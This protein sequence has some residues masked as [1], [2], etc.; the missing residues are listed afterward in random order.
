MD[1]MNNRQIVLLTMLTS[2][3]VSIAT[4]IVTVAMLEE[5]PPTLTQTVNRVVERTIER[6]VTGSSTP[7][8]KVLPPVTTTITK[9]V[10][11][12]AKEDDL[13]ISAVEKNQPRVAMIFT[14]SQ[15]NAS[16]PIASG[17]VVSRDGV[18]ATD[19]KKIST[20]TGLRESYRI[21]LN[22]KSYTAKPIKSSVMGKSSVALLKILDTAEGDVFDAVSFGRQVD[23]KIAQTVIIIGGGDGSGVIRGTLTKFNY[24]NPTATTTPRIIGTIST[25]NKI[26]S[27]NT[28]ALVINLDG[29]AVGIVITSDDW[30]NQVIFPSSR[31]LDLI[32]ALSGEGGATSATSETGKVGIHT[33]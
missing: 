24:L 10:T 25:A 18:I 16:L 32:S 22:G 15:E 3:I 11:I 29:Q 31:I 1:E 33:P 8:K 7:E 5:A 20:E 19:M 12:Y 28:G 26:P 4:G 14:V 17:F 27:D 9:E 23:P 6:V 2:F 13:I 30:N 21:E